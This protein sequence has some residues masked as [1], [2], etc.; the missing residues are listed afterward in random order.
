MSCQERLLT[1]IENNEMIPPARVA[2]QADTAEDDN[3]MRVGPSGDGRTMVYMGSDLSATI[4]LRIL[5]FKIAQVVGAV[6]DR[7]YN[8]EAGI[9]VLRKP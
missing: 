3:C 4:D 1:K 6:Y 2:R 7:D 9:S 8:S 5:A